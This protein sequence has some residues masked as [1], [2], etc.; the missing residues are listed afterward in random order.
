MIKHM[1][2]TN[3]CDE[4]EVAATSSNEYQESRLGKLSKTSLSEWWKQPK[5]E[6]SCTEAKA[7]TPHTCGFP[8]FWVAFDIII[9]TLQTHCGNGIRTVG[10]PS[11]LTGWCFGTC[12]MTCHIL[13]MSSS[14]LAKSYFSEG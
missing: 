13:G 2:S 10:F 12:F 6:I 9:G 11:V 4:D 3:R 5:W 8:H 14:Q 7:D 1:I